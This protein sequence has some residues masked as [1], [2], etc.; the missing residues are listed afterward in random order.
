[1]TNVLDSDGLLAVLNPAAGFRGSTEKLLPALR[2]L[3]PAAEFRTTRGPGHARELAEEAADRGI[4]TVVAVGGDGLTGEI[5]DGLLR[6]GGGPRLGLI[7]VGTGN[8]LSRSLG[9]PR[10]VAGAVE[11]LRG[12]VLRRIDAGRLRFTADPEAADPEAANRAGAGPAGA[13]RYFANVTV[14][15]FAGRLRLPPGIKRRWR[16]AAYLREAA[17]QLPDLRLHQTTV[18]VEAGD[19]VE[20]FTGG[21]YMVMVANGRFMGGGIQVAPD[22]RLDDALLDVVVVPDLALPALA[23]AASAALLFRRVPRRGVWHRRGRRVRLDSVP[24]MW[25]N[26]DGEVLRTGPAEFEVRP[27][28]LEVFVPAGSRA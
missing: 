20:T 14:A 10:G 23:R 16:A 2:R 11:I 8:D 6:G 9:I 15:G 13:D 25:L 28:A 5:V 21:S 22:A 24:P 26:A 19:G 27:G 1:M 17:G 18:T 7:P 12:G 4:G 3:L